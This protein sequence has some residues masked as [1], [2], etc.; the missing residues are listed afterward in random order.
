[1]NSRK[2]AMKTIW[3]LIQLQ[4]KAGIALPRGK[5]RLESGLKIGG[6]FAIGAVLL[7]VLVALYY[8]VARQFM[9]VETPTGEFISLGNEFLTFT[10]AGFMVLQTL[11]LI[12]LLIKT[13]DINND[14]EL[15]LKLPISSRQIFVSKIIVAYMYE[16]VFAAVVLTPILIAFGIASEMAVGYYFVLPII[17]LFV[18][19][20]PFFLAICVMFPIIKLTRFLRT[21]SLLTIGCY[22]LGLVALIVGY[23]Y[24]VYGFVFAIAQDGFAELLGQQASGIQNVASYIYPPKMFANLLGTGALVALANMGLILMVSAALVVAAYFIAEAKYKK[25]YMDERVTVSLPSKKGTFRRKRAVSAVVEKDTKNIFRSSNYTFQFLL[26]AVITPLLV[27]FCNRIAGYSAYQSFKSIA[28]AGE[29][30]HGMI[31]GV[32]LLVIL[33][34]IPLACS[35]AASNISREGYNLYHTKLVPVSYRKQLLVKTFIVFVPILISIIVSCLVTMASYTLPNREYTI[36]GMTILEVLTLFAIAAPLAYGYICMG[37]YLDLRKPLCNQVGTG[38][39]T[40]STAYTNLVIGL[41]VAIGLGFGFLAMV[42]GFAEVFGIN[43]D[44]NHAKIFAVVFSLAFASTFAILLHVDGPK[45]Y[46]RLE[47]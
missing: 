47:Q 3:T 20:L 42:T 27:F 22:L 36:P 25:V 7:G 4:F 38:E 30:S 26:I 35:F 6:L 24:L 2:P 46:Q 44:L 28:A 37:T 45:R 39:L 13:M 29:Q 41:G 5:S 32:S 11:F 10:L 34:L 17:L 1:M 23:M 40:K 8:M 33:V 19:I 16:L 43:F 9:I 15:L 21:R 14:R 18:P 31:F 12:P